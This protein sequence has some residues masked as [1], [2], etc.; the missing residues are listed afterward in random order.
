M[1]EI[2]ALL[3]PGK[4]FVKAPPE[5]RKEFAKVQASAILAGKVIKHSVNNLD[6]LK[7]LA[8]AKLKVT[9]LPAKDEPAQNP[10]KPLELTIAPGQTI[11]ARVRIERNGI[12]GRVSFGNHDSGR[13]LPHGVYVDNIGLSGLLIVEGQT[14]REFFI[15]ADKW[16]PE[17]TRCFHLKTSVEKGLVSQPIVLHVRK[18]K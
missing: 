9:I 17:M 12:K 4:Q 7:P 10:S 5:K 1:K 16:V 15:T 3:E 13:N 2:Q 6:K 11:L 14:E 8:P 18:R